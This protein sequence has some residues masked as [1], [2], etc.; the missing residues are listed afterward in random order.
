MRRFTAFLFA[1]SMIAAPAFAAPA[2]EDAKKIAQNA[3]AETDKKAANANKTAAEKKA[4]SEK[5]T[6]DA[7]GMAAMG[8]G[9]MQLAQGLAQNAA[10]KEGAGQMRD[11]Q[12]TWMCGVGTAAADGG[13]IQWKGETIKAGAVGHV[14]VVPNLSRLLAEFTMKQKQIRAAKGEV[15]MVLGEEEKKTFAKHNLYGNEANLGAGEL[16]QVKTGG[17]AER[18]AIGAG[19][20]GGGLAMSAGMDYK[21]AIGTGMITGG[22]A[23]ALT[24]NTKTGQAAGLGVAA[25][26]LG[27]VGLNNLLGGDDKKAPAANTT[28]QKP[29]T[30]TAAKK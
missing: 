3:L 18:I 27:V 15:D 8:I 19:L 30:T 24:A 2:N 14:P 29:A 13:D 6:K 25:G 20:A 22:G 9:G 16:Y 12:D 5:N 23:G 21:T 1:V 10:E 26:G 28:A 11:Y 17:G 4:E 7:L